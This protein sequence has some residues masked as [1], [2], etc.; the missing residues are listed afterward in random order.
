MGS[1]TIQERLDSDSNLFV[2]GM[3]PSKPLSGMGGII[4]DFD[5]SSLVVIWNNLEPCATTQEKVRS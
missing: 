1:S 2:D 4:I 3:S 5:C